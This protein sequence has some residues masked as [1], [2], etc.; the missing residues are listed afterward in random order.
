MIINPRI[1]IGLIR[2]K[3]FFF[4]DSEERDSSIDIDRNE[5]NF[6]SV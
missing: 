5:S 3:R 2:R 6:S 1:I 4:R